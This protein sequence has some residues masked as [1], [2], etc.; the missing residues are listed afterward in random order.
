MQEP[1]SRMM[2]EWRSHWE[3]NLPVLFEPKIP[4]MDK[5]LVIEA[6]IPDFLPVEWWWE[7]GIN[8]I[9]P[10]TIEGRAEAII[11]C[12]KA[13]TSLIHTHPRDSNTG[14]RPTLFGPAG[15]KRHAEFLTSIMNLV[16]KKVII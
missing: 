4:T 10:A 11:E 8:D 5:K 6:A 14:K 15:L 13:G 2:E 3:E 12:V 16:F 1:V 9:P 7:R